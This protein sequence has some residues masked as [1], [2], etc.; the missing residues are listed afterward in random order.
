MNICRLMLVAASILGALCVQARG[1]GLAWNSLEELEKAAREGKPAAEADL[2]K[3]YLLASEQEQALPWLQKAA[4]HKE[5]EGFYGLGL[6]YENGAC[7]V[8]RNI[9]K[10]ASY[11]KKAARKNSPGGLYKLAVFLYGGTGMKANPHKALIYMERAAE[12]GSRQAW[13]FLAQVYASGDT[14]SIMQDYK[15]AAFYWEKLADENDARACL[16]LGYLYYYGYGVPQDFR[17]A[18]EWNLCAA[19]GGL[20]EGQYQVAQAYWNGEGVSANRTEAIKWWQQAATQG[21]KPAQER[22]DCSA[23]YL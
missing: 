6:C 19:Q 14:D 8:E 15:K 4:K 18:F 16:N 21:Y 13:Q 5:A 10:A 23:C 9:R 3:Y 20:A 17:R 11:Y 22:V 1:L 12:K 7:G 2:G